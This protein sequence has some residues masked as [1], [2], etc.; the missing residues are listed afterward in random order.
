MEYKEKYPLTY[1]QDILTGPYT[2]SYTHLFFSKFQ[3]LMEYTDLILLDLKQIDEEQH[4]ILTGCTGKD[5][6]KRQD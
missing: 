1:H 5:V 2:V 3:K 6:Y 4:Q